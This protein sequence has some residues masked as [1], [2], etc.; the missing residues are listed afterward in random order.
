MNGISTITNPAGVAHCCPLPHEDFALA[1]TAIKVE[2]GVRER[3]LAQALLSL[4]VRQ[5][6]PFEEA[7]LHG[8][9]LLTGAPGTGKTTLARGLANQVGMHLEHIVTQHPE[10]RALFTNE[11]GVFNEAAFGQTRNLLGMVL[12]L[13][14][15][16][17]LSSNNDLYEDKQETYRQSNLIWNELMVGHVAPIQLDKLP[18]DLR[19][20]RSSPPIRSSRSTKSTTARRRSSP[21]SGT[22]G[23]PAV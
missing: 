11:G 10:N 1:W 3:L 4:T 22:S 12:L 17:N 6:L 7:P 21:R 14:D 2:E 16:L 18:T 5:K 20:P 23:Q 15:K 19:F 9:I 13:T 8:L